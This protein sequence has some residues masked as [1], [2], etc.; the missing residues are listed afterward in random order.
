[1]VKREAVARPER[2]LAAVHDRIEPLRFGNVA[3][4]IANTT[5]RDINDTHHADAPGRIR[6]RHTRSP[7]TVPGSQYT[8]PTTTVISA[9]FMEDISVNISE[10]YRDGR[11]CESPQRRVRKATLHNAMSRQCAMHHKGARGS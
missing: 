9:E 5:T 2:A 1:M 4:P 8:G 11:S 7:R 3:T 6:A 10:R